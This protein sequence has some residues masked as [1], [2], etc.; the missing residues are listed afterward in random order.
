MS[1]LDSFL[2]SETW[3]LSWPN[4]IQAALPRGLPD[5]CPIMLIV[6]EDNWGPIYLKGCLNVRRTFQGIR[7]LFKRRGYL[8]L[9]RGGMDIS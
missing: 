6:Y 9:L 1:R 5:H 4:C 8:F 7:S 3:C 2:L